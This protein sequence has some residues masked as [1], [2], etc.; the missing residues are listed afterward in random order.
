M[1]DRL[2]KTEDHQWLILHANCTANVNFSSFSSQAYLDLLST[3][4]GSHETYVKLIVSSLNFQVEGLPRVIIDKILS[5]SSE[6]SLIPRKLGQ[7]IG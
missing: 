1:R 5:S 2:E 3:P 7:G 4:H 6:V